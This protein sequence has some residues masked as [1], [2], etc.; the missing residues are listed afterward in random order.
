[1]LVKKRHLQNY[2]LI[3][4]AFN[5]VN[6]ENYFVNNTTN[7]NQKLRTIHISIQLSLFI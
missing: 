2:C 6:I 7:L 5:D 3:H 1:M 4:K